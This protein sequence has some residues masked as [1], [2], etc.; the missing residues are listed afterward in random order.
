MEASVS[1]GPL[2]ATPRLSSPMDASP[3]HFAFSIF[4]FWFQKGTPAF[5]LSLWNGVSRR[6]CACAGACEPDSNPRFGRPRGAWGWAPLEPRTRDKH[7]RVPSK[8]L[9]VGSSV[10]SRS[11]FRFG[12]GPSVLL[13]ERG[14]TRR[15]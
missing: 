14:Q 8:D 12:R 15:R 9:P 13:N 2:V 11:N 10:I 4:L 3:V 7:A 1:P 6:V 5:V